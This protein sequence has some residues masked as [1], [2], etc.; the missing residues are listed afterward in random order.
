MICPSERPENEAESQQGRTAMRRAHPYMANAGTTAPGEMLATLGLSD[1]SPLF[2]QIP[3]EHRLNRPLALPPQLSSEPELRR[4]LTQMINQTT[5]CED[6]LS[7]LG[8]GCYRHYVPALCD[9]VAGRTEWLTSVWGTPSSDYGRFQ[10]WYEY[11]SQLGEL[12]ALDFVGLPLYSWGAA[13][14]HAL[15]MAARVT[16][17]SEVLVPT[18]LDRERRAVIT[19]YCGA[20]P[21]AKHLVARRFAY[22]ADDG[23]LDLDD[24]V[25]QLSKRTAA[26]YLEAPNQFGVV[27]GEIDEVVRSARSVGAEVILGVDPISLGVLAPPGELGVGLSVGTT[28]SLGI[29]MNAGGGLGGFIASRDEERYAREYPTLEV[30]RCATSKAGERGF[31]IALFDQTSYAARE[32]ANDWTGNSVYLWAVVNAAYMAAMGP[33]GL[34]EVGEVILQRGAYAAATL[35]ELPGVTVPFSNGLFREILVDFTGTNHSVA[36]IN[37]ELRRRGIFGGVDLSQ[38]YPELGNVSLYCVTELHR[39]EDLDRLGTTLAEVLKR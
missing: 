9:E 2:E 7:F 4:H 24:L 20:E 1:P 10:A 21:L 15:R 31:A 37:H 11:A 39:K 29:H 33:V 26:V 38:S 30:S 19:T 28:Q 23:R 34:A 22:R 6:A 14:G 36:E 17:R 35:A 8:A 3:A 32:Q 16:G 12:L 13:A 25:S 18:A 27:E 5:S